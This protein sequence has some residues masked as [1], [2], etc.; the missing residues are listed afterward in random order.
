VKSGSVGK[1]LKQFLEQKKFCEENKKDY[2]V[3]APDI[4]KMRE[5]TY[6]K[7]GIPI[8]KNVDNIIAKMKGRLKIK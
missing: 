2:Y 4:N 3:Y 1:K 5:A 8:Y 7:F 6:I